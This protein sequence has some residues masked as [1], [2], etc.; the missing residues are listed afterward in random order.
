MT[1]FRTVLMAAAAATV[2]ATVLSQPVPVAGQASAAATAVTF[3]KDILPIFQRSCQNCHRPNSLAPM[4]LLTYEQARPYASAIK[5]RTSIRNRQGTMPPWYIEKNI[6]IQDYKNDI[7]LSDADLAKIAAWADNGAPRG[8]PADAPAPLTFNDSTE[9]WTIGTPDLVVKTPPV[10][11]KAVQPDWWGPAG[12]ADTGL[13]EDRYVAA[14]EIKEVN[15]QMGKG[16]AS[17]TVG[18]FFIFH[19]ALMGAQA[20]GAPAAGALGGGW[21]VHEVGRNA[22][23]FNPDAGKLLRAG[24][25]VGFGNVHMHANGKDTTGHLEIAFKF[26]P[27]DYKPKYT[28]RL[29]P[30]G[31]GD[32]DIRGMESGQK[33]E[34]FMTLQAP[35]KVTVYE[36]HMH[37]AAVR[38]CF[39]AI[40]GSRME[41][42]SCSGYDHSWVRAYQ[43]ADNAAPLLPRGTILRITGYYDNTPANRNVA[44]PRNWSG[45]GHRS[46]D[47]MNIM[48]MQGVSL[49]DEQ[50]QAEVT[51][52]RA[53]LQLKP[54][55]DAPG[56]PLC[57]FE[58]IPAAPRLPQATGQQ[59]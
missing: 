11:V 48:I 35:T 32:I 56:C 34:A 8:N 31:T 27:K 13:T 6:G 12:F 40:Y 7:S 57:S 23:V 43:Y 47:N 59:Q 19:H 25:K 5:R 29:M 22:D 10:T 16:N 42:L 51:A 44:D 49:T 45:L 9:G 46:I 3:N 41:T 58:K 36:P 15:D 14:V 18:G 37:A 4:S 33:V 20:P 50:F 2:G 55:E 30:I 39:D 26:H 28:E 24:S 21:P 52:R 17:N 1:S 54:G 53:A 38:M